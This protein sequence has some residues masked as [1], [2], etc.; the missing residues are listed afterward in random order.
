[1]LA[2]DA[3]HNALRADGDLSTELVFGLVGNPV[4]F[5]GNRLK[6]KLK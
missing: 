4:S 5:G 1:M 6:Y 2:P 3:T